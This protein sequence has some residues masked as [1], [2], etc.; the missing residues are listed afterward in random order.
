MNSQFFLLA[1]VFFLL[2]MPAHARYFVGNGGEGIESETGLYLRDLFERDLHRL[3]PSTQ[4]QSYEASPELQKKLSSAF[5]LTPSQQKLLLLKLGDAERLYPC[6]GELLSKAIVSYTWLW[7]TTPLGLLP[8][9]GVIRSFPD[10]ERVQIANRAG[11]TIHIHDQSWSRLDD[12]N[13]VGLILH[14]ALYSLAYIEPKWRRQSNFY[15]TEVVGLIFNPT[16]D[17]TSA[18]PLVSHLLGED[19]GEFCSARKSHFK[20]GYLINS[21]NEKISL[22]GSFSPIFTIEELERQ[23][24]KA[25]WIEIAC[26]RLMESSTS[27]EAQKSAGVALI[28]NKRDPLDLEFQAYLTSD[29][30]YQFRLKMK[31][32]AARA[33]RYCRVLSAR[34]LKRSCQ[35]T[36]LSYIETSEASNSSLTEELCESL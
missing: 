18:S 17:P 22:V 29:R 24:S 3:P 32:K 15:T 19:N 34:D 23:S 10:S 30:G 1:V 2:S 16:A 28:F 12:L 4:L 35:K 31:E 11:T 33:P 9:E 14:E 13:K 20:I 27:S 21:I 6:L 25:S 7:S 26:Q 5:L 8:E 36:I